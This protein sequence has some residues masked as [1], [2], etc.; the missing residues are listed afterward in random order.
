MFKVLEGCA[1][2]PLPSYS[3]QL[4]DKIFQETT[5]YFPQF[6][7]QSYNMGIDKYTELFVNEYKQDQDLQ[8]HFDHKQTYKEVVSFLFPHFIIFLNHDRYLELVY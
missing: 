5:K 2:T 4:T 1:I 8:F 3:Q 7:L 6:D